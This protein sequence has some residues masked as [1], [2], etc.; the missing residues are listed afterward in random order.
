MA[1]GGADEQY[2]PVSSFAPRDG[3]VLFTGFGEWKYPAAP[4]VRHVDGSV[5]RRHFHVAVQTG[6]IGDCKHG[7]GC[8]AEKKSAVIAAKRACVRDALRSVIDRVLINRSRIGQRR[9]I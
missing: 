6:A 2:A 5:S 9:M 8:L 3:D 4:L 7:R 1:R